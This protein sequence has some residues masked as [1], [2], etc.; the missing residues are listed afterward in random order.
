MRSGTCRAPM[1]KIRVLDLAT[2]VL[3]GAALLLGSAAVLAQPVAADQGNT[4]TVLIL[5]LSQQK[6]HLIQ[7]QADTELSQSQ[8]KEVAPPPQPGLEPSS[9]PAA[10]ASA[11]KP[12][13]EADVLLQ[14]AQRIQRLNNA[15]VDPLARP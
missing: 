14:R 10:A 6:Q 8:A 11:P 1:W 5:R 2:P 9:A 13:T 12:V 7:G 3:T 15:K 4:S